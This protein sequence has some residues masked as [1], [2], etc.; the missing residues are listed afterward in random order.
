[1]VLIFKT[2]FLPWHLYKGKITQE[3][4]YLELAK[5]KGKTKMA[6]RGECKNLERGRQKS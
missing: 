1:M 5:V 6:W 2:A 3:V 4:Y